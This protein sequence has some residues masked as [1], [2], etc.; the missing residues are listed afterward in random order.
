MEKAQAY[1][2][3]QELREVL[4]EANRQYYVENSPTLSD[5]EFDMLLK[6]LEA[7]EKEYPEFLSPDSPTQHVGSDIKK[8]FEQFPHRYPMLSLGNTYDI[9]EVQ[10]FADRATKGIGN[11]F[12]YSC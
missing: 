12:T 6:E 11:S 2:R 10:A 7:L 8:E 4:R 3:I 1:I 5:Y 9:S